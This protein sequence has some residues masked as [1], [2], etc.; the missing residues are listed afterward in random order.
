M[1]LNLNAYHIIY[2]F[3]LACARFA[4][5]RTA[6][7]KMTIS[8]MK[9]VVNTKIKQKRGGKLHTCHCHA[10]EAIFRAYGC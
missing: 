5:A 7:L 8:T 9:I 6:M 3:S 2:V 10:N 1:N 4:Y